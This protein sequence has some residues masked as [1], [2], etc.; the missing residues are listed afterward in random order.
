MANVLTAQQKKPYV[1][2][3]DQNCQCIEAMNYRG[4]VVIQDGVVIRFF[5]YMTAGSWKL[6]ISHTFLF[7]CDFL[8]TFVAPYQMR[9][10]LPQ[11][12]GHVAQMR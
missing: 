4:R 8:L 11:I 10:L 6:N 2:R 1:W 5:F 3:G 9:H 12:S 7:F